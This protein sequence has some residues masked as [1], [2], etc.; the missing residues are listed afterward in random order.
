MNSAKTLIWIYN[1]PTAKKITLIK[2]IATLNMRFKLR[3]VTSDSAT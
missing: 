2:Y 3:N 1:V